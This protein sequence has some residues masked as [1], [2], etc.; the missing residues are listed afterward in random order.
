MTGYGVPDDDM[1]DSPQ[2]PIW[3]S[4]YDERDLDALLSGAARG[5]TS[6]EY[7]IPEA[8][9]PVAGTLAALLAAPARGEVSD[10]AAAR[11]AFRAFAPVPVPVPVP[12]TAAAE[13][14]TV[15]SRTEV[16]SPRDGGQRRAARHRRRRQP[17]TGSA[18]W[19]A[20]V[21]AGAGAVAVIVIVLAVALTGGI[22]GSIKQIANLGGGHTGHTGASA[23]VTAT[24]Q[25]SSSQ[26]V[27]GRASR[28]PPARPSPARTAASTAPRTTQSPAGLCRELASSFYVHPVPPGIG[29]I[30]AALWAK[31]E[32]L[33]GGS[34]KVW[35]LCSPYLAPPQSHTGPRTT[36]NPQPGY[37]SGGGNP[38]ARAGHQAPEGR[39]R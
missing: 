4:A 30:R 1:P 26:R 18:R 21:A 3:G 39:R 35:S 28:V 6:E 25:P 12:W 22:G 17:G 27:D 36:P 8:L 13:H 5:L 14:G 37:Y 34:P 38:G 32:A 9:R 24:A 23:S 19:P 7:G 33:A 31:L 29:A 20:A 10:E 15:H 16:L 2:P 11:A